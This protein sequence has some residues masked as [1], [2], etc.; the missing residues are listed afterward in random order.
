LFDSENI[1]FDASLVIYVNS[2]NISPIMIVNR[3]YETQ[4]LVDVACFLP[5]RA[6]D[7]SAPRVTAEPYV[8]K[9]SAMTNEIIKFCMIQHPS[10]NY[11]LINKLTHAHPV[12]F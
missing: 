10:L 2:T 9:N 5:G 8:L 6:K 11:I 7:L 4:N 1:S 12:H 3:V